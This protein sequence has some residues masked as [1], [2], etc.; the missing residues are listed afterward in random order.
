MTSSNMRREEARIESVVTA[1]I[2]CSH[3]AYDPI[4]FPIKSEE[5]GCFRLN[6]NLP[7]GIDLLNTIYEKCPMQK[8]TI[9]KDD[10]GRSRVTAVMEDG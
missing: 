8:C 6:A 4:K 1:C 10:E 7:A 5:T 2:Q 3:L 9:V